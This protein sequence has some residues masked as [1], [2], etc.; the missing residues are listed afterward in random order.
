M[1]YDPA[2]VEAIKRIGR[3]RG[4]GREAILGALATGIV[5]SG[6]QNLGYGDADSQGWRQE[7]KQFYP[8]PRNV[9]AS[10]N[11]FFDEWAQHDTPG[12]NPGLTAANVQRPAEQFRGRYADVLD[13]AKKILGGG[14]FPEG[15]SIGSM[16]E[17]SE[18]PASATD[19]PFG[20]ISSLVPNQSPI[21][22][23]GWDLLG[24]AWAQQ[25]QEQTS[26]MLSNV[27]GGGKGTSPGRGTG[28]EE[29]FGP[30]GSWDNGK[31]I[32]QVPGH[33]GHLHVGG[34]PDTIAE[35]VAE[36]QRRGRTVRE[37]APVDPVDPVHTEGSYHYRHGG[38]GGADIEPGPGLIKWI[39][40]RYGLK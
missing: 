16:P 7:R 9:N 5:E 36:A 33:E 15:A 30:G 12:F 18:S 10:I 29:F 2:V 21:M 26:P 40:R 38:R 1:A 31:R 13:E 25:N 14:D 6:L 20:T 3:K 34:S 17:S 39:K 22:Q 8:N 27:G 24:K 32:A 23:Q 4:V 28:L 19:N 35:I 37:Y 11:R